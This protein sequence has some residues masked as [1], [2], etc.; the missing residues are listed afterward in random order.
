[1]FAQANEMFKGAIRR[2]VLGVIIECQ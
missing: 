2:R 1:M